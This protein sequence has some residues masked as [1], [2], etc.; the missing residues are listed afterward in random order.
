[1][2][3]KRLKERK[4]LL[5][6]TNKD[7]ADL[8]G[9]PLGTVQKIFGSSTK[10]PRRD[11]VIALARVLDPEMANRLQ[12]GG[13]V[14]RETQAAYSAVSADFNRKKADSSIRGADGSRN[15]AGE[16]ELPVKQPGEYTLEDYYNIPD[17]RRVELIDG[18]IYDMNAPSI[19]HQL[20][21][22]EIVYQMKTCKEQHGLPCFPFAAPVDVQLDRDEKTMVQPDVIIICDRNKMIRRCIYGAPEFVLEILSP[23]TRSKDQI[24]KLKK[25]KEAGCREYWVIDI[26]NKTVTVFMFEEENWPRHYTF[27]DKIPVGISNF[28][29]EI[30]FTKVRD[31]LEELGAYSPLT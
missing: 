22:A 30:D 14:I 3:I 17:E 25:Y 8:S 5:G 11:T 26:E 2:D 4:K 24:L 27:D 15:D 9:V 29:C 28:K 16:Y 21:S 19:Y 20:V 7:V 18:V 6:Y 31:Q 12:S 23:S 10:E 1:M 13:S